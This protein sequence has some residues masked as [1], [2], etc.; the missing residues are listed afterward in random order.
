MADDSSSASTGEFSCYL[1]TLR[2]NDLRQ[3][4]R[5]VGVLTYSGH[6][7][8]GQLGRGGTRLARSYE[9]AD[10]FSS[11][12]SWTGHSPGIGR[13]GPL[14]LFIPP[15]CPRHSAKGRNFQ[16]S[17]RVACRSEPPILALQLAAVGSSLPSS[18]NCFHLA[19]LLRPLP[20]LR[21]RKLLCS[22]LT[23]RPISSPL[24][25]LWIN[26]G[27]SC[28]HQALQRLFRSL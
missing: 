4:K 19:G 12:N 18:T 11:R 22:F 2:P 17:S 21:R 14:P 25:D 6:P 23:D 13:P 5:L 24:R 15:G 3:R 8:R 27:V 7:A 16:R 1:Y 10:L 26:Q 28:R 20:R 9:K